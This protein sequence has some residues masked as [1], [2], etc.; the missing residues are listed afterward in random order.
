MLSLIQYGLFV[1]VTVLIVSTK[2]VYTLTNDDVKEGS[3]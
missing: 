2:Y 1:Y 3:K